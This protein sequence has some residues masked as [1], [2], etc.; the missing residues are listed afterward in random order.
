MA[1][2]RGVGQAGSVVVQKSRILPSRC[3]AVLGRYSFSAHE[4]GSRARV[5]QL[6]GRR[7]AEVQADSFLI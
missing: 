2:P 1:V 6:T 4:A 3:S 7:R 5:V